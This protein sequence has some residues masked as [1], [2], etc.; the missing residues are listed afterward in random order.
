MVDGCLDAGDGRRLGCLQ[1]NKVRSY[2]R[3]GQVPEGSGGDGMYTFAGTW[4]IVEAIRMRQLIVGVVL[5][6]IVDGGEG[7]AEIAEFVG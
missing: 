3:M 6:A 4:T 1:D 7:N 5:P 2:Q